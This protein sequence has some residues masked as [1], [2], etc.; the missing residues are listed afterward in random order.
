MCRLSDLL[1]FLNCMKVFS[2]RGTAFN[3]NCQ[4]PQAADT[5]HMPCDTTAHSGRSTHTHIWR[6]SLSLSTV[7]TASAQPHPMPTLR[8]EIP[9]ATSCPLS[10]REPPFREC[11]RPR[12]GTL[13]REARAE[14]QQAA[15]I[16]T[17]CM[18][19]FHGLPQGLAP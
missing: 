19:V 1:G 4:L 3:V 17:R 11:T 7:P 14:A 10:A 9:S 2:V 6:N 12:S 16:Q 8:E 15:Q 18:E 5:P 13:P